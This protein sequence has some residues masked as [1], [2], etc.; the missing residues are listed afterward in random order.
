MTALVVIGL[1]VTGADVMIWR[2]AAF[3]IDLAVPDGRV[4]PAPAWGWLLGPSAAVGLMASVI[5]GSVAGGVIAGAV[6][7]GTLVGPLRSQ[8]PGAISSRVADVARGL[9]LFV[10]MHGAAEGASVPGY[11]SSV[12]HPGVRLFVTA[13]DGAWAEAMVARDADL[14]AELARIELSDQVDPVAGRL[15]RVDRPFWE[16]MTASW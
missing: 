3:G 12:G 16:Q 10:R 14:V 1:V 11:L 2:S 9:R 15:V 6:L 13:P 7:I 5:A 8:P 4:V